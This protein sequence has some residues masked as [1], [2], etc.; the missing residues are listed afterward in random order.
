[1]QVGKS[2]EHH[3]EQESIA[4]IS[5]ALKEAQPVRVAITNFRKDG[6]PFRNLLAMKPIMDQ[7]RMTISHVD[8]LTLC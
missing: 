5:M 6:R 8:L 1:M 7:V 3:A 2:P 4:R